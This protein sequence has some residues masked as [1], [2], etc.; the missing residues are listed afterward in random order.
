LE[1]LRD[2]VNFIES[3]KDFLMQLEIQFLKIIWSQIMHCR[4]LS[5]FVQVAFPFLEIIGHN[6]WRLLFLSLFF[7]R[8]AISHY[9]D[10]GHGKR[11]KILLGFLMS[12][13]FFL[14]GEYHM[15]Y[16]LLMVINTLTCVVVKGIVISSRNVNQSWMQLKEMSLTLR[17]WNLRIEL[18]FRLWYTLKKILEMLLGGL[19]TRHY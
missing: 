13:P 4:D 16:F 14:R 9:H 12:I 8:H 1:T 7:L 17:S 18:G 2:T 6:P 19:Y 11:K 10:N 3:S 15:N 5:L